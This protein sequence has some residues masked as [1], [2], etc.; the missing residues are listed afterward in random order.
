MQQEKR[1]QRKTRRDKG[2]RLLTPRDVWVLR[3]MAEQ[4]ALRFDQLQQLL[5]RYPSNR[6]GIEPG[7]GGLSTSAVLQVI[8]RWQEDPAWVE[9]QRIHVQTPGWI[10]LT[11]YGDRLLEIPYARHTLR[12]NRL[13]HRYYVNA[14]RLDIE[15]RHPEYQWVSERF[16]LSQFSRRD[17]NEKLAHTPDGEVHTS[18][19]RVI[20][21]EVELSPK[22]DLELDAILLE[23][24][25]R[26]WAV[27]YFVSDHD[28]VAVQAWRAVVDARGRLAMPFGDR[29][30][31]IPLAKVGAI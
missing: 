26:Y 28:P 21:V 4:Y 6:N 11:P 19:E 12:E 31:I 2:V 9:Y 8:A 24:L 3:W 29:V 7:P 30:Q 16:L 1:G 20:A 25:S 18:P 17:A 15:Q 22:T 23:L 14:V 27:W 13:T 10:W 5:S